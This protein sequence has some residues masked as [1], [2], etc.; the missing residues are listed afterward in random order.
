[1]GTL[2]RLAGRCG[3]PRTA[4]VDDIIASVS[5]LTG[6]DPST[7]RSSLIETVP[8]TDHELVEL[9]DQLLELEELLRLSVTSAG[10]HPEGSE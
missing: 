2:V 9:S 10:S 5:A 4:S 8:T 7:V 3:L 1:V 6:Q